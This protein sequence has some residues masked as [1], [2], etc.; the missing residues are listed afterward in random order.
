MK[1]RSNPVSSPVLRAGQGLLLGLG[2]A[3]LIWG[4][5]LWG[6]F[7]SLERG[8]LNSLFLARRF[9]WIEPS[10]DLVVIK[11]DDETVTHFRSWP[12]PR[13]VYGQLIDHLTRAGAKTIALDVVFAVPSNS[14]RDDRIF[15]R[16]VA[17]SGRVVQAAVFN[18]ESAQDPAVVAGQ[19]GNAT[20]ILP[21]F[22]I[23]NSKILSAEAE[24]GWGIASYP[25]LQRS[26]AGLG[27]VNAPPELDG[28]M[29]RIPHLLRF[30]SGREPVLYPSLALASSAHFLGLQPGQIEVK[31]EEIVLPAASGARRVPLDGAGRTWVNWIGP[32]DSFR[33]FSLQR[34]LDGEVPD[35]FFKDKIV[36]VGI[37]AAGSFEFRASP[38][39]SVQSAVE[40]QA[41]AINDI[42]MNRA[43]RGASPTQPLPLFL[44]LVLP[45]LLGALTMTR[46]ARTSG[47]SALGVCAGV[48]G[49]GVWQLSQMRVVLPIAAPVLGVGLAWSVCIAARQFFDAK[50]LRRAEE[51]YFL[52]VRGA[53]DG[54][55]DWD[56]KSGQI[57]FSPRWKAM[58]GHDDDEIGASI[59]EW[60]TRVHPDDLEP[61]RAQLDAHLSGGVAH[62]ESRHRMKHADGRWLW[63]LSRGL[64]ICDAHGVPAR[65]AGSQSD[66]SAQVRA[67]QTIEH[68]AFYDALTGLPNRALFMDVLERALG[69][70]KGRG[71]GGFAVLLMDLNRFKTVNESLGHCA[72][73]ELLVGVA[74]RISKCLRPGDIAARLGGDEF[75]V[76]LDDIEDAGAATRLAER[77][78]QELSQPFTIAE[79]EV[80]V[81]GS[82]GI[83]LWAPHYAQAEELLRDADT[84]MYRAKAQGRAPHAVFDEAMHAQAL[85]ALRL[86]SDLRRAFERDEFEV[87]YQPIVSLETRKISGFEALVRWRHPERG[88]VSPAQFIPLAEETGLIL[89]LDLLV[90]RRACAQLQQWQQEFPR[91]ALS[92]SANLSSQQFD[93]SDFSTEIE[94]ILRATELPPSSLKLEITE[95]VLMDNPQKAASVL[96]RL[97]E[98][99]IRLALD[100]FGTGYSSLSYL[101]N[102]PL[103]TLKIDQSFVRRIEPNGGNLEI[104][105]TIVAL[106]RNLGMD[107]VAEG[108]ETADQMQ[109]LAALG[110]DFGQGYLFSKPIPAAAMHELLSAGEPWL[111]QMAELQ[112][113]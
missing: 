21:R 36:L 66:I 102:F 75:T 78:H 63:V 76:L 54:L 48:W 14:S 59:D 69:R 46:N 100:D 103:D 73:D 67:Q 15:D 42:L 16:A 86:E 88:L 65:M 47:F 49:M 90:L 39:S 107:V 4:L 50:Q 62:F 61:M 12:L 51:R 24:T 22:K 93:R 30:R 71:S 89:P 31:S 72:G 8:A 77:L 52:A 80:F 29:R 112:S 58:L 17:R 98:R 83:A 20:A 26:A 104:V 106:A 92:M 19:K 9:Q 82:I 105:R 45:M 28:V 84:A 91:L 95:G 1:L 113:V 13:R 40:L 6:A 5:N 57:Y 44:G 111:G 53:N 41:N 33:T 11:A 43:L 35:A 37:T 25:A 34:V 55:W 110:C 38:F 27:H 60:H 109:Q 94:R 81:S 79:Q 68:N 10:Q 70:V 23:K 97:R 2:C 101:H 74:A 32:D 85:D 18:F 108:V 99:G 64:R 56:L 7:L 87:F 3:L 96:H